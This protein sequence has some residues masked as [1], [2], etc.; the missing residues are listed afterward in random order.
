MGGAFLVETA[1]DLQKLVFDLSIVEA[2]LTWN[3]ALAVPTKI[4]TSGIEDLSEAPG[5][6]RIITLEDPEGFPISLV[7]G[8]AQMAAT[9][10]PDLITLNYERHKP[11]VR[12]FQRFTQG[13]A[14]VYRVSMDEPGSRDDL[15][16]CSANPLTL[17]VLT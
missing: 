4:L 17:T 16:L 6:G 10:S 13:P 2:L 5:G 8:Q 15:R 3:R 11:R 7:H 1:A 12:K 14:P 9:P